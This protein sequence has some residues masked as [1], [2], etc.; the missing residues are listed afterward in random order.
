MTKG[1]TNQFLMIGRHYVVPINSKKIIII[2]IN[3]GK[4]HELFW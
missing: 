1:K 2:G 4:G 3:L